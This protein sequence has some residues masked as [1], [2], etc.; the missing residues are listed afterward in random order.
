MPIFAEVAPL[1]LAAHD[2]VF[3][4]YEVAFF[5]TLTARKLAARACNNA[6]VLVPHNHRSSRRRLF[7]H[8]DVSAANPGDLH[9]EQRAIAWDFRHRE[10]TDLRFACADSY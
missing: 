1:A 9:F 10:F 2:I 6:N 4:E 3:Q 8:L 7:V 5:E